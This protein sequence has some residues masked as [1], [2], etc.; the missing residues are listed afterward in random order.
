LLTVNWSPVLFRGQEPWKW[1]IGV[2]TAVLLGAFLI[3]M[4]RFRAPG[5]ALGRIG[6][7]LFVAMYLGLLPSFL[8]QLRRP[9]IEQSAENIGRATAALA[10]AIFVPKCCDIGAYFTGRTLGRHKMTPVL[11]P[12]KTWEGAA[13]GVAAAVVVAIGINQLGSAVAGGWLGSIGLGVALAGAGI[14]GDLAESLIKRDCSRKDA[15]QIMPGLGGVLDVIDSILFAA[16][17]AYCWI[18]ISDSWTVN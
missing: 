18:A 17:V 2:G 8:V 1:L 7:T 15:S 10:L 13:G 4:A 5:Q 14:L 9:G 6:Q 11:S 3:E 16:P 12:K